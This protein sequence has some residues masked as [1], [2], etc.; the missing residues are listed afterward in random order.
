MARNRSYLASSFDDLGELSCQRH[1][2]EHDE[3]QSK[4]RVPDWPLRTLDISDTTIRDSLPEDPRTFSEG[5]Y[6]VSLHQADKAASYRTSDVP[7]EPGYFDEI[8]S[9]Y[10]NQPSGHIPQQA[11]SNLIKA[12]Q[13]RTPKQVS[14][15]YTYCSPY[16]TILFLI[17][18]L[19][20]SVTAIQA[21]GTSV[22]PFDHYFSS[23]TNITFL[24]L[25]ILSE[26]TT[27]LMWA[28]GLAVMERFQ[29]SLA[30]R[31]KGI[32]LINFIQLDLGTGFC[33]LLKL[34]IRSP[35]KYKTAVLTRFDNKTFFLGINS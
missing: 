13:T 3:I 5:F 2:F 9:H 4:G 14:W 10:L 31:R 19:V 11:D 12:K 15:L 16:P 30:S 18:S 22:L 27:I 26:G 17:T 24:V 35:W 23:S 20:I 34:I 21:S 25:R 7:S 28:L 32:N 33:G 6:D 8:V 29:W 1:I